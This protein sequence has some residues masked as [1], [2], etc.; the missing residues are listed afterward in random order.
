MLLICQTQL[1]FMLQANLNS[2]HLL[3][4]LSCRAQRLLGMIFKQKVISIKPNFFQCNRRQHGLILIIHDIIRH[5]IGKDPLPN[6][7]IEKFQ[8]HE[9][10]EDEVPNNFSSRIMPKHMIFI[11]LHFNTTQ[12]KTLILSQMLSKALVI[13]QKSVNLNLVEQYPHSLTPFPTPHYFM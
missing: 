13:Y 7:T 10:R 12:L 9:T 5:Q 8:V 6:L 11:L 3:H 2:I 4:N 1:L